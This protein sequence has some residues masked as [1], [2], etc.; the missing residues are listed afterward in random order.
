ML[1]HKY[2]SIFIHINKCGGTSIDQA[3]NGKHCRHRPITF[4]RDYASDVFNSYFKFTLVR[5]PWDKMLSFYLWQKKN[6]W[7]LNWGWDNTNAPDFN[8]FIE[9]VNSFDYERM[10]EVYDN[11]AGFVGTEHMRMSNQLDW[12][13]DEDGNILVDYIGRFENYGK[14]FNFISNKVGLKLKDYP[15]YNKTEHKHYTHYYNDLSVDII[16]ERFS[17]DIEYFG[18]QFGD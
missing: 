4:Y 7:V 9:I 16:S 10:L 5:N 6:N 15:H 14:E 8:K 18:Y 3:F 17:K 11:R 2:K 12:I 13:T 1:N